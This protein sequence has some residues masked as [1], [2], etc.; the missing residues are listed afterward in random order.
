[1]LIRDSKIL[2]TGAAGSVGSALATRIYQQKPKE[3]IL[4]DQD[5]TGIF[6]IHGILRG[7]YCLVGD[8]INKKFLTGI[9][10]KFRPDIVFHCAAYKHVPI[11]EKQKEEAIDNNIYGTQNLIR[12][13]TKYGVK[14]FILISTDKAVNPINVMGKTKKVCELMCCAQTGKTEFVIARFGNVLASRGSVS[15]IFKK[16]IE[17]GK[18]IEVTSPDMERYFIKMQDALTLILTAAEKGKNRELFVWDMGSPIKIVDLAINFM[19]ETK[20]RVKIVFTE[21]R[22]GEKLKEELFNKDEKPIKRGKIFV[23]QLPFKKISLKRLIKNI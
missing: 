5:E 10:K 17:L 3:L 18:Q 11:M 20:R 12:V 13:A 2:I 21:P 7:A 14:K 19:K 22:D 1:M 15:E 23:V 16:N 8:I 4:L 9:F 6:Y